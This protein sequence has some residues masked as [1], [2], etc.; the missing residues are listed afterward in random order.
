MANLSQRRDFVLD[1]DE[2]FAQDSLSLSENMCDYRPMD[3]LSSEIYDWIEE[4]TLR[5]NCW[6]AKDVTS[7]ESLIQKKKINRGVNMALMPTVMNSLD[8]RAVSV[9][10][11][12]YVRAICRAEEIRQQSNAKR[13]NRFYH[14]MQGIVT[15]RPHCFT[16]ACKTFQERSKDK[17]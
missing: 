13:T 4:S 7:V 2:H 14:Y 10:L 16:E 6:E 5:Q 15:A 3:Q 1:E 8:R 12:P 9:D 11:L 17:T